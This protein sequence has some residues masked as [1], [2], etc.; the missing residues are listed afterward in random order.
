[1]INK[2]PHTFVGTA[3]FQIQGMTCDH[4]GR[5]VAAEIGALEG[6][7]SV[8]V[9]LTTDTVTVSATQPVDRIDIVGAVA[10]AGFML[11]T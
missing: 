9:D 8:T 11:A 4:C 2:L 10:E 3:M 1:M 5:A 6:V 7:E